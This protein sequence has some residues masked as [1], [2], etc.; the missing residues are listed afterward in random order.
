MRSIHHNVGMVILTALIRTSFYQNTIK[1]P[2][3]RLLCEEMGRR[4]R[5]CLP[6]DD[7]GLN[8][9]HMEQP[10]MKW[11][12]KDVICARKAQ[13]SDPWPLLWLP[14]K[15]HSAFLCNL[16]LNWQMLLTFF[17][18]QYPFFCHKGPSTSDP[19]VVY[20]QIRLLKR[21]KGSRRRLIG[22][23]VTYIVLA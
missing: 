15:G 14:F 10:E 4:E 11:W 21:P 16:A 20:T 13:I 17:M 19:L 1:K 8:V 2:L 6:M 3:Y 7:N 12:S 18:D 23:N 9:K 22:A 5:I